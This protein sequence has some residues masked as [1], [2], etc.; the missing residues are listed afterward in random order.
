MGA[1]SLGSRILLGNVIA[2]YKRARAEAARSH[3]AHR[4]EL[5]PHPKH[6]PIVTAMPF[7]FA[8]HK[9]VL[10]QAMAIHGRV[11]G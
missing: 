6:L 7:D 10:T 11:L 9:Y 3:F 4:F 5:V 2:Y 1:R 8:P